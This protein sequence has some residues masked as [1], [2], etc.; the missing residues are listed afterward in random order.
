MDSNKEVSP[1]NCVICG[2]RIKTISEEDEGMCINC[3]IDVDRI[4]KE[5][6]NQSPNR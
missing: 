2:I 5:Q 4:A 1:D 3:I 6:S